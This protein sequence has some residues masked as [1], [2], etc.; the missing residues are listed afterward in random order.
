M[1]NCCS[2]SKLLC[3]VISQNLYFPA[4][5]FDFSAPSETFICSASRL[6]QQL[7]G[8]TY[9]SRSAAGSAM[10][11]STL[12]FTDTHLERAS[13]CAC[14]DTC[15][16]GISPVRLLLR[17]CP[18]SPSVGLANTAVMTTWLTKL[19]GSYLNIPYCIHFSFQSVFKM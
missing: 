16:S 8:K 5:E 19:L 15:S 2:T 11:C 17:L 13:P 7:P 18:A 10:H 3:Q 12:S 4:K 9:C 6:L 14:P 1:Q